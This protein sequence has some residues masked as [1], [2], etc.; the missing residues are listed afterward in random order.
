MSHHR[1]K[2]TART[3]EA[4]TW[5]LVAPVRR[6]MLVSF[7]IAGIGSGASVIPYIALVGL[8]DDWLGG[9]GA[10]RIW[11][12]LGL[13]LVSLLVHHICY[14]WAVG[15][16]HISEAGLRHRLRRR[17]VEHLGALPL[18]RVR[19]LGPGEIRKIVVDDTSAIHTLVA[20]AS[21]ELASAVVAPV[22][23][24]I[25]L[26]VLDWRL[27]LLLGGVF[28]AVVGLAMGIA[29]RGGD[30]A[31]K[32][33]D[34]AQRKL[35][36]ATVELVDG[37]KEIKNYQL[38]ATGVGGR[39]TTARQQ[40]SDASF[41]WLAGAGKGIAVV[42]ALSQPGVIL[43]WSAPL[44]C[45]FVWSGWISPASSLAFFT[46]WLGLP[47]GLGQLITLTQNLQGSLRAGEDTA[48]LLAEKPQEV[49]N[50]QAPVTASGATAAA[51]LELRFQ[52]VSFGYMPG[53]PVLHDIS[54]TLPP[55]TLTAVVG[56][57]GAGKTTI[58]AL[59]ARFWDPESGC[60]TLG[61]RDLRDYSRA[62]LYSQV[63]TVFQDVSLAAVSVRDNLLLGKLD[64][65][66][67]QI[68]EAAAR[69]HI[70]ERIEALPAG[71]GTIL[72]ENAVLS[73]GE[74]QRLSIARTLLADPPLLILDEA[75]AHQDTHTAQALRQ[76]IAARSGH[77]STLV[78]AHRLS[79]LA[80]ADHILVINN[81][82]IVQSGRHE[83]LAATA[84]LY[85][86]ML[87][88]QGIPC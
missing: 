57:S 1:G 2:N 74:A 17:I 75:S 25:Y 21:A 56:P 36:E 7:I 3:R 47:A 86:E 33:Y 77:S 20:H 40:N 84:G 46:I 60:I 67:A 78:I 38:P 9:R 81:G 64:A 24:G 4:T 53:H 70:A 12:W 23:G 80:Q 13:T 44:I 71:Y 65:T 27:A 63:G 49:G 16:T 43:A 79:G 61:G 35:A 48:A 82:R 34:V 52:N 58:G 6:S 76:V 42:S 37:I 66:D 8:A 87:K 88:E 72:G 69:A 10:A 59:A 32:D 30:Q 85:R 15:I 62:G 5:Q 41:R 45:W 39:F 28:I 31:V 11:W 54:F 51:A 18:G 14:N 50:Y 19:R 55:G 73:G 83:E 29:F 26:C 68:H 22:V